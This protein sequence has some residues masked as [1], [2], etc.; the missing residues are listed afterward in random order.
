MGK[1]RICF[2]AAERR[3]VNPWF[4]SVFAGQ[5]VRV[6]PPGRG[7]GGWWGLR[8]EWWGVYGSVGLGVAELVLRLDKG[9]KILERRIAIHS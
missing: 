2:F 1:Y 7:L 5:I 6:D 8:V 9:R 3:G 4:W